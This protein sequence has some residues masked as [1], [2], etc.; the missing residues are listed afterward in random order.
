MRAV[1]S[2]IMI[3]LGTM[4]SVVATWSYLPFDAPRYTIG[5]SLNLSVVIASQVLAFALM[6]YDRRENSLRE[7]GGRDYRLEGRSKEEIDELGNSHPEF[8]YVW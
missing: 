5:N 4:G 6:M 3:G 2:A 1:S 7:R 8:R